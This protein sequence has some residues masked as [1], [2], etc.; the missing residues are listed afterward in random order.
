MIKGRNF[1]GRTQASQKI[2]SIENFII[3]GVSL[4]LYF[5][6]VTASI[7][8]KLKGILSKSRNKTLLSKQS[9]QQKRQL[10]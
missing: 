4:T 5:Y 2:G 10:Y 8:K 6:E 9:R 7:I 3:L 1:I